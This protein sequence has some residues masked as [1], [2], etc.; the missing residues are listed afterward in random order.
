MKT[1]L[2]VRC[3]RFD[4]NENRHYYE[5]RKYIDAG[6]YGIFEDLGRLRAIGE[7]GSLYQCKKQLKKIAKD[8]AEAETTETDFGDP[9]VYTILE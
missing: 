3:F 9:S 7:T 8:L 1:K 2:I 6:C 5:I 4:K